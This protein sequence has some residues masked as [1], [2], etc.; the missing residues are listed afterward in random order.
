MKIVGIHAV[1]QAL[2]A[3]EGKQLILNRGKMNPRQEQLV[4]LA[5]ELGVPVE[6]GKHPASSDDLIAGQGVALEVRPARMKDEASLAKYL[7]QLGAKAPDAQDVMMLLL[8]GVT[9]PRNFGACIRSAATFG[10]AGIVVPKDKAAPLNEAA[11]KAASGGASL[12]PIF[13][14]VNL[15]RSMNLLKGYNFW[16]VG[17]V[18]DEDVSASA[19]GKMSADTASDEGVSGSASGK[20]SASMSPVQTLAETNLRGRLALVMGGEAR[21]LRQKTR[22]NCDLLARIPMPAASL[23]LNVS[24]ATGICL[25]EATRQRTKS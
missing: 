11:V 21:G 15:A 19:S 22:N 24:V 9:D 20:D 18:P 25:Y 23:S 3:G 6:V 17:A 1:Q 8:D 5:E 10:V 2:L 12:V 7:D 14:V 4:Q 13:E 16:L